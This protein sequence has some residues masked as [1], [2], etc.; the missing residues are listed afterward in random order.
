[1]L[2]SR[3]D[4][5]HEYQN[6]EIRP[7]FTTLSNAHYGH[8]PLFQMHSLL[9]CGNDGTICSRFMPLSFLMHLQVYFCTCYQGI[10][11]A[12]RSV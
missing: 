6:R 1:M 4:L 2:K 11:C 9:V 3:L 5:P 12:L 8:S 10:F 7:K